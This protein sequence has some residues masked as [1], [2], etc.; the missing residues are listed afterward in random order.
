MFAIRQKSLNVKWIKPL[1]KSCPPLKKLF[2]P[3]A[4]L[5]PTK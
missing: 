1:K 2:S 5:I 3:I 4:F